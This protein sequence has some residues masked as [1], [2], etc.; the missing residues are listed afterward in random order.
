MGTVDD[1]VS[2]SDFAWERLRNRVGGLMDAVPMPRVPRGARPLRGRCLP[3]PDF[4]RRIGSGGGA[5]RVAA[6]EIRR[7]SRRRRGLASSGASIGRRGAENVPR[8]TEESLAQ[9]IG[10]R[11]GFYSGDTRRS[12]VLHI[13]DELIH[14]GA[15]AALLRDLYGHKA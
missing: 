1:L 3:W 8:C 14:H 7:R 5:R 4:A 9:P 6:A 11:A 13:L 15:E 2:L 10:S 12:F